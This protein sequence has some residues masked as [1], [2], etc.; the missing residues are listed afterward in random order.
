MIKKRKLERP[1]V[2]RALRHRH[3]LKPFAIESR[4][5]KVG[6]PLGLLSG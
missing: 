2:A 4:L 6:V 5:T 3:E 1:L